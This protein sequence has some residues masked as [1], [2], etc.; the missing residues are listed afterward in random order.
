[1]SAELFWQSPV[2]PPYA[3]YEPV[4]YAYFDPKY[5]ELNDT[6]RS[7]I[8]DYLADFETA[9]VDRNFKDPAQGYRAYMDI[10]SLVDML[11]LNEFTKEVDAYLFSHY[12][13]KQKDSDGGLLVNGPPWDYNLA[14]GNND[15]YN[16][17]HL[18]YNLLYNQDNIVY[19]WK[20]GRAHV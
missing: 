18:T 13:Y 10:P 6:Q 5:K 8:Q 1:M 17:V 19:W 3:G 16:D 14:L 2:S 7:Y 15:Y 12:F 4:S 11:I 9:L 20:I